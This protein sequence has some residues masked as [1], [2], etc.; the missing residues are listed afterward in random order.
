MHVLT[1]DLGTSATKAVLWSGPDV[2][3][4][5]RAAIPTAH[6]Q[7]GWAEQDP[8]DWWRSVVD[9]CAQI[10]ASEPRR[11]ASVDAIGFAAA[12]ETFA[13]FDGE[14]VPRRAG[15]L[16]SDQRAGDVAG[17]LGDPDEVRARTGVVAN[18][19]CCAAK[20]LWVATHEADAFAAAQWVL[21]PR[22]WVVAR[23]TGEV[24]TEPT[25]ESR[26]GLSSLDGV[27]DGPVVALAGDRLPTVVPTTSVLR[28]VDGAAARD[29][30]LPPG[31][32]VV[33][34][35]GD[36]TCEVLGTGAKLDIPMVSWGTTAN[37][38]VPHPG[39]L[40]ALP[41]IAAVSR[42]GGDGFLV[43]A[44]L[45]ASGAALA[46][47]ATLTGRAHDDLLVA[48]RH[49]SVA[50]ARGVVALPWL[51]GARGPYWRSDAHAAFAG[52]TAAHTAADLARA[53]VEAVATDVARCVEM[54]SP[55]A[56]AIE[57]AGGGAPDDLWRATV[58]A[59]TRL[60]ARR[61]VHDDA[62]SVGARLVVARALG[63]RL[64]VDHVNPERDETAPDPTLVAAMHDVRARADRLVPAVLDL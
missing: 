10:R 62:A 60:P 47:L 24:V 26:T 34:G 25:L 4:S 41:R 39:P 55:S 31:T 57:L 38:S 40:G 37:V 20:L 21:S 32:R 42:D 3:A 29:L 33:P 18:G 22:D 61:R 27:R 6:P 56:V 2:V 49:D 23:L 35:A 19:A 58:G 54:L 48:A 17:R 64:T 46:W 1:I 12:R 7:P 11:Y 9:A 30:V 43:E 59:A 50:G 28:V 52:V 15:V 63:E 13:L 51:N 36:R 14:L 16:W 5:R 44:G 8:A 53:I 45:S